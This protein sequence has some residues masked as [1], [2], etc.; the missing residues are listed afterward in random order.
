MGRHQCSPKQ[1]RVR[2]APRDNEQVPVPHRHHIRLEFLVSTADQGVGPGLEMT[3][4]SV[5]V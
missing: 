3:T 4:Q 2:R 5:D 1:L